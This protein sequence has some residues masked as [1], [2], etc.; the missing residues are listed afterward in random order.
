MASFLILNLA[1]FDPFP[2]FFC[3]NVDMFLACAVWASFISSLAPKKVITLWNK[4]QIFSSKT[5]RKQRLSEDKNPGIEK[6]E[7]CNFLHQKG[8]HFFWNTKKFRLW[9]CSTFCEIIVAETA[10]WKSFFFEC[11]I[12]NRQS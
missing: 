10:V 9:R 6:S 5:M 11:I 2:V 12:Q 4:L 8:S 1:H 3:N 7:S